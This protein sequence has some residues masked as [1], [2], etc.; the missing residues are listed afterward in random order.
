[1]ITSKVYCEIVASTAVLIVSFVVDGN[2]V[3]F[4]KLHRHRLMD[5]DFDVKRNVYVLSIDALE[6]SMPCM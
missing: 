5:V 6:R 4:E 1:M 3:N 2:M